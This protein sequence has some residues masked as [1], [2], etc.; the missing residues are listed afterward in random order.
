MEPSLGGISLTSLR[1]SL[2]KRKAN[3]L[4]NIVSYSPTYRTLIIDIHYI[5][6]Y[7]NMKKCYFVHCRRSRQANLNVYVT[8]L[9]EEIQEW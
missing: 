9:Q 7:V 1:S 4:K 3:K 5:K 2:V 8:A 6:N